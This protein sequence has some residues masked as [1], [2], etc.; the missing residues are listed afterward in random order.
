MDFYKN[1]KHYINAAI[2]TLFAELLTIPIC[3]IKTN[4]QVQNPLNKLNYFNTI[5]H[6]YNRAGIKAFFNA[7]GYAISSQIITTTFKYGFYRKLQTYRQTE[8]D[9]FTNNMLNG[10][11]TGNLAT[12]ITHPLEVNK[13]LKQ[14]N[15]RFK[16]EFDKHGLKLLVRGY[17][18]G[19][20]KT[21]IGSSIFYPIFD[22]MNKKLNNSFYS[23]LITSVISTTIMH[24]VDYLKVRQ[25]CGV[26]LYDNFNIKTMYSGY[27]LNLARIIPHF[28]IMMIV[29]TKLE[30]KF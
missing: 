1:N 13:V 25:M 2:A 14:Q 24:P 30:E 11:I 12:I 10:L 17:S 28:T 19:A 21:S 29:I 16:T 9:D 20:L 7:S 18:K 26:K 3:T 4:Y 5:N 23:G 15:I 27:L 8:K 6:I 22:L